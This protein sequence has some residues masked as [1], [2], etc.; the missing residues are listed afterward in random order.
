MAPTGLGTVARGLM[1]NLMHDWDITCFA[2]NH[3][4]TS[5]KINEFWGAGVNFIPSKTKRDFY[6]REK[7]IDMIKNGV[8][9]PDIIFLYNDHF[10]LSK[11][12]Q[13]ELR[14]EKKTGSFIDILRRYADEIGAKIVTYF[15]V[16]TRPYLGDVA[17]VV[18]YSHRSITF[19][20]W[21]MDEV[22]DV[23]QNALKSNETHKELVGKTEYIY[24]GTDR[25]DWHKLTDLENENFFELMEGDL[26][27][28]ENY[29]VSYVGGHNVRKQIPRDV[30]EPFA[31]FASDHEDAVLL[32]KCPQ[33]QEEYWDLPKLAN[34]ICHENGARPNQIVFMQHGNQ[35]VTQEMIRHLYNIADL[36][37]LPSQEGWGLPVTE[38]MACGTLTMVGEHAA[39]SE[40]GGDGRS[41]KVDIP[42]NANNRIYPIASKSMRRTVVDINDAVEKLE[43]AY[44]MPEQEE[45]E[46]TQKAF[47]FIKK[48]SFDRKAEEFDQIFTEEMFNEQ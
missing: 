9:S 35:Y 44:N 29:I 36:L 21:A 39:L 18:K 26:V 2:A 40:V 5:E 38:A 17:P 13:F 27:K 10:V 15:P 43:M 31:R 20:E 34:R 8:V 42:Q 14:G 30:F 1:K 16:D 12:I 46:I 11:K 19:T 41:I 3:T 6:G 45:A 33:K 22:D 4:D 23:L 32:I 47:S 25:Q 48:H 7:I 24:H 37:Y 28:P